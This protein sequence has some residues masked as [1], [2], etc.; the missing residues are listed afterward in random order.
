MHHRPSE[1]VERR[2]TGVGDYPTLL[3]DVDAVEMPALKVEFEQ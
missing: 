1:P 2:V 3:D